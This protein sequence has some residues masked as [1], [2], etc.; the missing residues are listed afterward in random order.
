MSR[1]SAVF[2]GLLFICLA[3]AQREE[4]DRDLLGQ[5]SAGRLQETCARI[6]AVGSRLSG[7][8]GEQAALQF[9]ETRF[10]SLGLSTR[11]ADFDVTVPDPEARGEL[12]AAGKHVKLLPLWPNLIRTSTCDLTGTL[13]DGGDGSL[14]AL[15][16]KQIR[17]SIVVLSF[18]SGDRWRNAAGLG[19][20]AILFARPSDMSRSEAEQKFTAAPLDV[21]RFLVDPND[22]SGSW[23]RPARVV[24]RQ[25]WIRRRSSNVIADLP[26]SDPQLRSQP[27]VLWAYADSMSVTPGEAPGAEQSLGLSALLELAGTSESGVHRRPIRFVVSGG[28]CLALQG[29]REYVDR[30]L[31]S[32][33][34]PLLVMTLDLS[35]ASKALGVFGRG[36]AYDYRD[37]ILDSV[38]PLCRAFRRYSEKLAPMLGESQPRLVLT[39]GAGHS[40]NRTW[41]TN[42]PAKFAFDCEPFMSAGYSAVTFATIDD[43][44]FRIDS[45]SDTLEHVDIGNLRRQVQVLNVMLHHVLND[46]ISQTGDNVLPLQPPKPTK[47]GLTGGFA[48]ADGYVAVYDPAKSLVP[49]VRVP[50]SL[51][52]RITNKKSMMGVRGDEVQLT[53]GPDAGYRFLGVPP[54]TDYATLFKP[55]TV[56]VA[57][58]LDRATG[59]IDYAPDEGSFGA[60]VFP[61]K[62]GLKTSR[63]SSPIVLFPCVATDLYGLVDP[64][65]FTPFTSVTVLDPIGGGP[66]RSFGFARSYFDELTPS[67]G[68][69]A[70]VLFL[71]PGQR[72]QLLM[73]SAISGNRLILTGSTARNLAGGGYPALEGSMG[74]LTL[75]AAQNVAALDQN[76][77]DAFSKYR[78]LG[79][80][81]LELHRMAA[82]EI[83]DAEKAQI[84][85]DWVGTERSSRAAWGYGLRA[86]PILQSTAGD[87]VHGVIF[88][89]FLLIPFSFFV[90]RLLFACRSL[91]K[92]VLATAAVFVAS[93][94]CLRLVHPAFDLIGNPP[95]I[96]V[97][98]VMGSLSLIVTFFIAG[99]F[100]SALR[101]VKQAASGVR[102]LDVRRSNVAMAAFSL[103]ISNLRRRKTR[104]ILTTLTL[105]VMTFIVLSFTSVVPELQLSE[106]SSPATARYGGILLRQPGLEPLGRSAYKALSNEF[107]GR[108]EVVRRVFSFGPAIPQGPAISIQHGDTWAD[109]TAAIG[110]DP[111]EAHLTRPQEALLP[112]G[113]WFRPG[114]RDALILPKPI[115]DKLSVAAGDRV[116]YMGIDLTVV[117]VFDPEGM[118][119]VTD[120]DGESLMPPDQGLT[121]QEQAASR[122]QTS[123]FRRFIRLDPSTCFFLPAETA[124]ALGGDLRSVA[125]GFANSAAVAASMK[126][127]MPRLRLNL[128]ASVPKGAGLEVR[129][130]SVL[131]G[132]KSTGLALV[133]VQLA[134][135]A[136]FV[137]NTMIASVY[138][139]TREISI[140]SAIGLAPNHIA[141][142]FFAESLV[143]G[144]LGVVIGYFAAQGAAKIIVATNAYPGL[145]LN[146]SST[147]AIMSAVLVIGVVLIS[148]IYPA[149]KAAQIAAPAMAEQALESEPEG[150][151][152]QIPLPFS[153]PSSEARALTLFLADWL[154]AYEGYT[155]GE[156][157]TDNAR[158]EELDA[159]YT[160]SCTAWLSPYD[161]GVSEEVTIGAAQSVPEVYALTLTLNRLSGEPANWIT[162]NR[163]FLTGIRRQFLAW[164]TLTPEE[165]DRFAA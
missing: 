129:R 118:R 85:R 77:I 36:Y 12:M 31:S 7:S 25:D 35:S 50:D 164:R 110:L 145:P 24:C 112:G 41:K 22:L 105:T 128:Y 67:E 49:D 149:R 117:G 19:A 23:N 46:P 159:R 55:D 101:E 57:Y 11:R 158:F 72:F 45:A 108:A 115:A 114:E 33:E 3:T 54:L 59:R 42:I 153:V 4:S 96:F 43:A 15:G 78:L 27:I 40:D 68:D 52:V 147:S 53:A 44:R 88:Y 10:R 141:T 148:T 37:E 111:A 143:Y 133:L 1:I 48:T 91:A 20:S 89:S 135:A 137:L 28:H 116:R 146:F 9:A 123:A 2:F 104:T 122:S 106:S 126:S 87:I 75:A 17:G 21:P 109:A 38:L 30:L 73:G 6:A 163:R 14:E 113:R 102:E 138:E 61:T 130:F 144:V 151:L 162:L 29:A 76:R 142:L 93:F 165:R 150:D 80:S 152:W 131:Q 119:R 121:N 127:L 100:E 86:Q 79:A 125:V 134:I 155:I 51:A 157:V 32:G 62:I 63:R 139:R 98:F 69:D 99:K 74:D 39:D 154:K 82:S 70:G 5:P 161:L 107:S 97:G 71:P 140:F 65:D 90:E 13:I 47:I 64:Q 84:S 120:L 16:G 132:A 103:G 156:F 92:Q 95:M 124:L 8:L 58:H 136:V 56:I 60:E 34:T 160:A 26:G 66:P 18:D 83:A 81:V 94:I